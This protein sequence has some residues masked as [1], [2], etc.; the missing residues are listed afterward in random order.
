MSPDHVSKFIPSEWNYAWSYSAVDKPL[1]TLWAFRNDLL[2]HCPQLGNNLQSWQRD[3]ICMMYTKYS[4]S[5]S[6]L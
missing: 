4:P 2:I 3:V 1:E 5:T 6:P